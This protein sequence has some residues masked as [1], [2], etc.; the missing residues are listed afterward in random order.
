MMWNAAILITICSWGHPNGNSIGCVSNYFTIPVPPDNVHEV[1]ITCTGLTCTTKLANSNSNYFKGFVISTTSGTLATTSSA[2][3]KN[4]NRCLVHAYASLKSSVIFTWSP[5]LSQD[6]TTI[7]VTLVSAK[8]ANGGSHQAGYKSINLADRGHMYVIGAG[9]GGLAAARWLHENLP[10]SDLTVLERGPEP[11]DTWYTGPIKDTAMKNMTHDTLKN[12]NS[13]ETNLTSMVGGQQNINGAVY[14]PGTPQDLAISINVTVQQA[15]FLQHT[16]GTY[17]HKEDHMMWDCITD[18]DCDKGRLATVNEKMARRSIAYDLPFS[19]QTN[20]EVQNV[21]D[22]V[23]KFTNGTVIE[24]QPKDRV[25]LAAGAL[26][27]PQL[28]GKTEFNGWNHY[29]SLDYIIGQE[30]EKQTFEYP[31][32]VKNS[33]EINTG[34]VQP[35]VSLVITMDMLP[36][37][38]E[39]YKVGEAYVNPAG[40]Y[41]AWHFAGTMNHSDFLVDGF[42]NVFTGDAGALRKPFNCHTSMPAAAAGIAAAHKAAGVPIGAL[43]VP[44]AVQTIKKDKLSTEEAIATYVWFGPLAYFFV[45][46]ES[47]SKTTT[48]MIK[49]GRLIF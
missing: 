3:Y 19:V 28:I 21:T 18:G 16:A 15:R 42:N 30:V 5:S 2:V 25:I 10:T 13:T 34:N 27:S 11:P 29:Y 33:T 31:D 43:D 45:L 46:P 9:P 32:T 20:S 36:D 26:V 8:I 37:F 24:L 47:W 44:P 38:R 23:I 41:Q 12:P 40:K 48:K 49:V 6:Y 14:A 1:D 7:Y 4:S 35:G 17:V 39:Y 22:G